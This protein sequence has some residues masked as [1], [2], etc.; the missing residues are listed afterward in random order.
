MS[1]R[2]PGTYAFIVGSR[3][4]G[5]SSLFDLLSLHSQVSVPA[6]KEPQFFALTSRIVT[7]HLQWYDQ[8]YPERRTMLR[9]DGSTRYLASPNAPMLLAE[10]VEEPRIIVSIRDPAKRAFSAYLHARKQVPRVETRDFAQVVEEL[11]NRINGAAIP[12][13]EE[14]LLAEAVAR[15]TV[16]TPYRSP[17]FHRDWLG[18]P[19][20]TVFEDPNQEFRYFSGSIYQEDI[21]RY[22]KLFGANVLVVVFEKLLHARETVIQELLEFLGLAQERAVFRLPHENETRLPRGTYSATLLSFLK[23]STLTKMLSSCLRGAGL[24]QRC[25]RH[26]RNI[27]TEGKPSLTKQDYESARRILQL[28]YEYWFEQDP[29]LEKLWKY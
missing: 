13:A 3:K 5:T 17:D 12:E 27:L 4:C 7:E 24:Y 18:A 19:Y 15:G 10:H 28:E 1:K 2:L 6:V 25:Y 16:R 8:L 14:Q 11:S 23:Q 29:A 26:T 9:L 21:E 20:E 22:Q